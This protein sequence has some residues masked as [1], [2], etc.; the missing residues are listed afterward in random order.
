MHESRPSLN[1]S[2]GASLGQ[3]A[4]TVMQPGVGI[5]TA[6]ALCIAAGAQAR[7]ALAGAARA[8]VE[9]YCAFVRSP[10]DCGFHEQAKAPGR[11]TLVAAGR[12]GAKG[13]RLRTWPGDSHVAGSGENERNDLSLSQAAT[14][15]YAGREHWWAHSLLF[16]DDY[17][18]PPMSAEKTWNWSVV[19]NFHN[20]ASGPGQSN[21]MLFAMPVRAIARDRPTG[22]FMRGYGGRNNGDGEFS[23]AVG[24]VLRNVWYDFVYHVRW[25][26]GTDGYFD[27]W[28]RTGDEPIARRV[29]SHRGPTLYTGQGV[30]LKPANYHSPFGRPSSVIHSRIVRGRSAAAVSLVPLEGIPWKP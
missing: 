9:F 7:P 4:R 2:R 27:A 20:T 14:D 30:Y 19:F 5:A 21:F 24:P 28:V 10:T 12:G 3:A 17:V 13:V 15:G 6:I 16:P 18:D 29:L 23:A 22:L 26:P 11:A 1:R 8:Q 25:S